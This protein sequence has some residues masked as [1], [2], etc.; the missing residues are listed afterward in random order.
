MTIKEYLQ[1]NDIDIFGLTE[2]WL[3]PSDKLVL[4][5]VI[6]NGYTLHQIPR[7]SGRGG[8]VAIL[9]K[10]SVSVIRQHQIDNHF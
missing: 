4:A 5:D 1:E 9:H 8:G 3:N 10:D 2:T 7:P 6:P